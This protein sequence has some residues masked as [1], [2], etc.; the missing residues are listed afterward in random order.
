MKSRTPATLC[1]TS[2]LVLGPAALAHGAAQASSPEPREQTAAPASAG[3]EITVGGCVQREAD[4]RKAH[5]EG[6]GGVA[7]TGV[8]TG[9]E[10]VLAEASVRGGSTTEP[11]NPTG[12]SG[13][14]SQAYELTGP[15]EG[16]VSAYVGRRVEITGR[17]KPAA[18]DTTGAPTG[19]PTAGKPPAG[20]DV[21]SQDLKL[22]ELE[23][24]SVRES[25][26]SCTPAR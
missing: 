15:N 26:G 1:V 16:K 19:G 21:T 12:T 10:F 9:N 14:A 23:V 7:G 4:F 11:A 18:S 3:Q 22:R 25:A 8:G 20:V 17:L 24:T 2:L 6:R 13:S 5:D